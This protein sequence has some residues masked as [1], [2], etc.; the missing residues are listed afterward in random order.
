[1]ALVKDVPSRSFSRY[2]F[3]SFVIT[4]VG[5][6]VCPPLQIADLEAQK[7]AAREQQ[8]RYEGLSNEEGSCSR[9]ARKVPSSAVVDGYNPVSAFIAPLLFSCKPPAISGACGTGPLRVG[10]TC[11]W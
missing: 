1:M 7:G 9:L 5:K 10:P 2:V 6:G 3:A 8:T 11:P 4:T